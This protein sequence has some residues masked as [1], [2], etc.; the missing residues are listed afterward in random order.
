MTTSSPQPH[1]RPVVSDAR[2]L[3]T[4]LEDRGRKLTEVLTEMAT[5]ASASAEIAAGARALRGAE[6]EMDAAG[7]I[8]PAL[9]LTVFLPSNNILYSCVLFG[10]IP[11]TYL[12]QVDMRPSSRAKATYFAVMDVLS[13]LLP[14]GVRMFDETQREFV[15]RARGSDLVV[16]TGRLANGRELYRGMPEPKPTFLGFGSGP[17]PVVVGPAAD[18]GAAVGDLVTARLHNGGQDCLCPDV[19]FVHESRSAEFGDRLRTA[20]AGVRPGSRRDEGLVN[21][22]LSYEDAWLRATAFLDEHRDAVTWQGR[23]AAGRWFVPVTVVERRLDDLGGVPELFAPVFNV[24][25]YPDADRL[26]SWFEAPA[27]RDSGFY[28][29]VYGE[30]AFDGRDVLGT[31]VNCGTRSA[32]AAEDGNR[33]F[34]GFGRDAS[35]V[36]SADGLAG[37]PLLVSAEAARISVKS[38]GTAAR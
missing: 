23:G 26:L 15:R 27:Q 7:A 35:W 37:R 1:G 12:G 14:P 33:P 13:D 4:A 5:L 31:S 21:C 18:L 6:R 29:S 19:V 38:P 9:R 3:A 34:G 10:L 17:N 28:A 30:P 8:D 20:L 16:F 32:L 11:A 36:Q 24:V 22:P 25:S 2:L